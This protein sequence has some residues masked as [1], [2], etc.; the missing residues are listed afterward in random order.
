MD[1]RINDLVKR[2]PGTG[3][4]ISIDKD[5]CTMC[6]RCLIICVA[7]LWKKKDGKAYIVDDYQSK[8][9]ECAAC[10][11]VCEP[12]AIEFQYPAGGTGVVFENG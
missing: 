6:E 4:F 7:N 8:C 10:Y 11:Q 3:D 5:K 9:L 12:G 1:I 2:I